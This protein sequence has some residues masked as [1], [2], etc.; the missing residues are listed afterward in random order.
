MVKLQ[1]NYGNK[2]CCQVCEYP[3]TEDSQRHLFEECAKI[4][5]LCPD[6]FKHQLIAYSDILSNDTGKISEAVKVFDKILTKR[7]EFLDKN[8]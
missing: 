4:Q 5:K 2:T 3:G 8:L 6:I 7:N 1:S